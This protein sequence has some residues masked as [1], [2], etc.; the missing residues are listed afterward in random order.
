MA[1]IAADALRAAGLALR[2]DSWFDTVTVE[3]VDADA[4]LAA[5]RAVDVDLRR[6][7]D[8]TVGLSFDETTTLDVLERVL[9]TL[10]ATLDTDTGRRRARRP[11]PRRPVA[12]TSS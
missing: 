3:G 6:V 4:V 8:S 5:A 2:H 7:D 10:G 11:L 12:S 1:S 9:P